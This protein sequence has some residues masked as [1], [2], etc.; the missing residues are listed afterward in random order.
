[1]AKN[2]LVKFFFLKIIVGQKKIVQKNVVKVKLRLTKHFRKHE[3]VDKI[4]FKFF[5]STQFSKNIIYFILVNLRPAPAQLNSVWAVAKGEISSDG[6]RA[7]VRDMRKLTFS[8]L[9]LFK[10]KANFCVWLFS[11]IIFLPL[12]I[13]YDYP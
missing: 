1:M 10:N 2:N 3:F 13:S 9:F 7:L 11:K 6:Y 5:S 4:F 12:N 8:I